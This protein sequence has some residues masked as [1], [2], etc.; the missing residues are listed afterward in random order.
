MALVFTGLLLALGT[1][2]ADDQAAPSMPAPPVPAPLP[3]PG[4]IELP[5][6]APVQVL[7]ALVVTA[8]R[9]EVSDVEGPTALELYDGTEIEDSGAFSV[10]EFFETL[11]PGDTGDQQLVLINGEPAYLDPSMLPL[12]MIEGIEVSLNGSMPQYGARTNGRVINIRLKENYQGYELG[13]RWRAPFAGGAGQ[14]NARLSASVVRKKFRA[15]LSLDYRDS[16]ALFASE[17]PFSRE[18]DHRARGG[19]DLR[20]SWGT[21]A[22]V[23]AV[24]GPLAGL[25]DADGNPVSV[26]LV[27]E[28]Q[29]GLDLT[30]ADFLP[31]DASL[32]AADQRRFNT[33]AYRMLSSPSTR[34]KASL[35]L[36]YAWNPRLHLTLTAEHSESDR[37]RHRPPPVTTPSSELIVPG[38][39]NPFGQDV[40]FGLVH[41]EFGPVV[42]NSFSRE[43]R[44]GLQAGG[45][46]G[47]SWRWRTGVD[48]EHGGSDRTA[49]DLDP[50]KLAAALAHPDPAA[51]FNPFGDPAIGPVNAHLYPD[52]IVERSR[53]ETVDDVSLDFSLRGDVGRLPGGPV[54]LAFRGDH[55]F[56][57]R[58]REERNQRDGGD[59]DTDERRS[60]YSISS[61]TTLPWFGN[62]NARPWF[63]RLTTE[64]SAEYESESAGGYEREGE[65]GLAWAPLKRLVFRASVSAESESASHEVYELPDNLVGEILVDPRRGG[66]LASDVQLRMR[67]TITVRPET[68]LRHSLG[69]SFE[70]AVVPGLRLS[71]GYDQLTWR[72]MFE[73]D[74]DPQDIVNN[75]AAFPGRVERAE[76]T[77]EDLALGRPGRIVAID[78]TP[79]NVGRAEMSDIDFTVDYRVPSER[80]GQI[81]LTTRAT[82]LLGSLREIA[83]GVPFLEEGRGRFN[84]PDWRVRSSLGWS[85]DG[86]HMTMRLEFTSAVPATATDSEIAAHTDVD[87][88]FGYRF[89]EPLWGS[90][91]R[92]LHV[93]VGIDNVFDTEPP[94][95]D[96]IDGFRGGSALGRRGS[97]S[98]SLPL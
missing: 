18:Q 23:Q 9:L 69:F 14:T 89:R 2:R 54:Q 92:G 24:D 17:R 45:R 4:P 32:G 65:L 27:P 38:E 40:M 79:G 84:R 83:P 51:R 71:A 94:F 39:L 63:Q 11:P 59:E 34:S 42:E 16:N 25:R 35:A 47:E 37:L 87:W 55:G 58:E 76:P 64:L 97:L 43:S 96:T 73:D 77:A 7:D 15:M 41:T 31:G 36:H 49:R 95:A 90:F 93:A 82:R 78:V 61:F 72:R 91:G 3:A 60:S 6:P 10:D 86:W 67:D 33:S 8:E 68:S 44:L 28:G 29:D 52:L 46:L 70:P 30:V 5:A 85:R 98:V 50:D 26:A 75:E 13:A 1:A 74:F 19:R 48:Y 88:Y 22:V 53:R 57:D 21:P 81:R 56:R 62:E 80:L 66:E 20:L 12:G